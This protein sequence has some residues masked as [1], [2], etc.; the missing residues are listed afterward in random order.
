L[1]PE[2]KEEGGWRCG[3]IG[4][5]LSRDELLDSLRVKIKERFQGMRQRMGRR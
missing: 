5:L 2:K 1:H 4:E 3:R